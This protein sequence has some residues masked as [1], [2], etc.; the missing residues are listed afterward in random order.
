MESAATQPAESD[1]LLDEIV[2]RLV[3]ALSPE[4]IYLVGSR[5]R[6]D[7]R[8]DSDYDLLVVGE[9]PVAGVERIVEA[10]RAIGSVGAA[11]D[12]LVY[13]PEEFATYRTWLSDM[14]AVAEREGKVV[15]SAAPR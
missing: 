2:A 14:A 10:R 7:H 8:A 13:S 15:Y 9:S 5:A 3:A 4:R 6:G 1:A 11:V 12:L